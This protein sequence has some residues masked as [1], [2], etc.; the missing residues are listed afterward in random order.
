MSAVPKIYCIDANVLIQAWQKYYSPKICPSYW[1]ILNELGERS[2]IFLPQMV[3]EEITR[4][5]D[6]LADW[7]KNSNISI[8]KNDSVVI[9]CLRKIYDV[10]P[11]H[12]F[13]VDNTKQ[14]SLADPWVIAHAIKEK[15]IVVTKE[16]KETAGNSTKIKIPNVC[17]NMGVRCIDDFQMIQELNIQFDCKI[18]N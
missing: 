16:N 8:K 9:E 10:N 11:L 5:E 18:I 7:L 15:A 17:D 13:L 2:K 12:K 14:R 3:Y 4:T 6:D 1:D